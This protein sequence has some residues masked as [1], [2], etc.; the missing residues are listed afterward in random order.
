[1]RQRRPGHENLYPPDPP[2]GGCYS[3]R[4][5]NTIETNLMKGDEMPGRKL[6]VTK[7]NRTRS[8]ELLARQ[9]GQQQA[10]IIV[11][12]GNPYKKVWR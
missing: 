2:F 7:E 10:A 1:V 12:P 8:N 4:L 3:T 5:R 6:P 11:L 9:P